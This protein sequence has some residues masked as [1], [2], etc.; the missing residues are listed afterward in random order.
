[1]A[2]AIVQGGL[3]VIGLAGALFASAVIAEGVG[4]YVLE[5]SR[6]A[7]LD[8]CVAPTEVM[9][10]KHFEFIEHQRDLTVHEGIR[11]S[12]YSLAGCVSCHVVH[13]N[14]AQPVPVNAEGQFCNA[15]HEFAAVQLSCF[16]C[17]AT[18]PAGESWNQV[19]AEGSIQAGGERGEV[20][21]IDPQGEGES[22]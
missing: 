16:D 1:M 11:S 17:H 9:R 13:K 5:G 10:R 8:S 14:D 4:G 7:G 18:V 22:K 21:H 20:L 6:A 3:V 2:K 19:V 15:C 12:K